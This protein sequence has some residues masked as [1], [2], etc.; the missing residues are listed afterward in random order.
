MTKLMQWLCVISTYLA[1]WLAVFAD[2]TPVALS[3][4]FKEV[5]LVV[6]YIQWTSFDLHYCQTC[7]IYSID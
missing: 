7:K 5:M 3:D 6:S 1:V 2:Y 4:S